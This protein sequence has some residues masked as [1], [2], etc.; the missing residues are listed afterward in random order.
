M[1]QVGTTTATLASTTTPVPTLAIDSSQ[2]TD[3]AGWMQGTVRPFLETWYPKLGDALASPAYTAPHALRL[4]LDASYT[5]VAYTTGTSIVMS[6]TY[7]R[8]HQNDLGAW[9]HEATHALQGYT[10]MPGWIA[11]GIA[12]YSREQI[13]HDRSPTPPGPGNTYLTGYSEGAYFFAWITDHYAPTF[14][15][16][17]NIGCHAGTYTAAFFAT[18]TG[19]AI[20]ALWT[21]MTGAPLPSPIHFAGLSNKCLQA[22]DST[23]NHLQIATCNGGIPQGF[24]VVHNPDGT[25]SVANNHDCIDVAGSA[26]A[27]G[28][29][30]W[31]YGCNGSGAQVWTEQA[32]GSLK[33][34]ASGKC[35]AIPSAPAADGTALAL[36]TCD[37]SSAQ[38]LSPL[39]H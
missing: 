10:N 26:T 16:D 13:L 3:L 5:G 31:M 18:K 32:D 15:H 2:A 24:G 28:S 30:I 6:A 1:T 27:S 21:E 17:L 14:V 4:K 19:K 7:A 34:P 23:T 20:D 8:A 38:R 36:A 25:M 29:V 12:D 33:N 37:G 35:M 11:E 22:G 39:G 9:L